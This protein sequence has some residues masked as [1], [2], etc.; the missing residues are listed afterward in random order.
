MQGVFEVKSV[1]HNVIDEKKLIEYA[2]F[3]NVLPSH[4]ISKS[5]Q[6]AYGKEID[7]SE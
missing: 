6:R 7:R 1:H 2:A 4:P 3:A 5:L